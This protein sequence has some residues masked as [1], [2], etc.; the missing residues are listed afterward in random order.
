MSQIAA[1]TA[2]SMHILIPA[3][4]QYLE[5]LGDRL[6]EFLGI[7]TNLAE[8]EMTLYTIE[9]AVQEI[10]ANIV[11]HAYANYAGEIS[12]SAALLDEPLRLTIRIED[13]GAS[14]ELD[15]VPTPRL[16][17]LQEHGFGL[18]LVREL[19]DEVTYHKLAEKNVWHLSKVLPLNNVEGLDTR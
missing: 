9:L 7:L 11:T 15:D 12:L 1:R 19:M 2:N 6:R 10:A 3:E 4:L 14:F 8:P 16:G 17:E 18:F 13:T 5:S